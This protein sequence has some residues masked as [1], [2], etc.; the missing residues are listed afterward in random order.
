MMRVDLHVHSNA[1][2]GTFPPAKVVELAA[3][4]GLAA[5]ALTDHDNVGGVSEALQAAGNLQQK[6]KNI[7]VIPGIELSLA[8][9]SRD[10]HMLGFFVDIHHETFLAECKE[11]VEGRGRRNEQMVQNLQK[12]GLSICMEDLKEGNPDTV[13][14]R[15]H[16]ARHLIKSGCVKD[17]KEAFERY[18]NPDTPYYVPRSYISKERGIELIRMAGGIPVLAHPLSY[19]IG[20]K[21]LEKLVAELKEAGLAGLE[22]K[23]SNYGY[24]DENYLRSLAG[25]FSLLYSGG[26]DFHGSNKPEIQIGSGRGNLSVPYEYIEEMEAWLASV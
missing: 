26:S 5:M 16:F 14:T 11:A 15:A 2:D 8:Y 1:S 17:M 3:D 22:V 19:G 21:E 7:R 13:V 24:Q 25:R 9:K 23:Y 20:Q 18:L 12:A 10:I 6:G 4:A